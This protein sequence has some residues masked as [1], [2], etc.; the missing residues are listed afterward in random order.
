VRRGIA[1]VPEDRRRQGVATALPVREN[2]SLASLARFS[3]FGLVDTRRETAAARALIDTL[4]VRTPGPHA[5]VR[6]LSG[7]NQQKVAL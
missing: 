2:L 5:P 3:R 4:G 7:G 1:F 6:H